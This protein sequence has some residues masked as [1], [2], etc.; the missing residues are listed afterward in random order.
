M[1]TP[2]IPDTM[3][4][5]C[6]ENNLVDAGADPAG[7][8]AAKR[9]RDSEEEGC[10]IRLDLRVTP[11]PRTARSYSLL[12]MVADLD[13]AGN[14]VTRVMGVRKKIGKCLVL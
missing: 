11:T 6:N 9:Q 4:K 1:Q 14:V 13:Q 2:T 12:K 3:S 5:R 7:G 10:L 8:P